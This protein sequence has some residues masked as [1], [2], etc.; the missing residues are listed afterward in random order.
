MKSIPTSIIVLVAVASLVTLIASVFIS[1][2]Y[3]V[4]QPKDLAK[5]IKDNPEAFAE[6]F[7][8]INDDMRKFA[9]KKQK[10]MASQKLKEQ[11]DN[12]IKIPTEGRV[13]FGDSKAPVTIVEYFDF[14]CGYCSL[15]SPKMKSLVKK[16]EGKVNLVYKHFP[17]NFHPFAEPAAVHFEAIAME[18]HAKAQ[19]FHDLIFDNFDKY[20][21]LK[22]KKAIEN[23]LNDLVK[24]VGADKKTLESNLEKA[25]AIVASDKKEGEIAG[26]NGTPSFVIN[27]VL[28]PR[29]KTPEEIIDMHIENKK[30]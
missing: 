4:I 26:V 10:E 20:A 21:K 18:D 28:V 23:S 5:A 30:L 25:E 12:P 14:Q 15:A 7:F 27:G 24:T 2:N 3:Y 19:K 8:S 11:F 29:N 22:D 1:V 6:A 13:T 9:Q 17:L 16:Y